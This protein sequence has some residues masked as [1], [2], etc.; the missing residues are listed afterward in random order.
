MK[1]IDANILLYAVD[2]QSPRHTP[3]RTWLEKT[4]SGADTVG[5]TW[6]VLLAFVRVSTRASVFARPLDVSEALDLVDSWLD[7][8]CTTVLGPTDRHSAV[9][10]SLLQPLGAAGNLS[11]DAHLAAIAIEH[12]AEVSSCDT[13]FARFPGLRWADPLA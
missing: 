11:S 12:G 1:V 2:E 3:A 9:L 5:L 10:R 4:L 13:D 7:Q 6:G 8:P